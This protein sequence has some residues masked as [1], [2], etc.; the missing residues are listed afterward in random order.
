MMPKVSPSPQDDTKREQKIL[1]K[2]VNDGGED[3]SAQE[4]GRIQ[5]QL[6]ITPRLDRYLAQASHPVLDKFFS[7]NPYFVTQHQLHSYNKFINQGIRAIVRSMNADFK[8]IKPETVTIEGEERQ[9]L[10]TVQVMMGGDEEASGIYLDRPTV[11]DVSTGKSRLMFPNEA[12][13]RGF[14]YT[15]NVYCDITLVYETDGVQVGKNV[16]PRYRIGNI[17]VMLHSDMCALHGQPKATLA[18]M[19]E[20]IYDH[21]GYFVVDGKEKVIVS[22]E[23]LVYNRL[24]VSEATDKDK[25]PFVAY[26]A[27]VRAVSPDGDDLFPKTVRFMVY[28]NDY[29]QRWNAIDIQI[30][31]VQ[32]KVPLFVLFRALGLESDLRIFQ[33]VLGEDFDPSSAM[34]G[35]LRSCALASGD[36]GVYDQL[37]AASFLVERTNYKTAERMKQILADDLFP[38]AG[39]NF[40]NK[41]VYLAFLVNK[42]LRVSVGVDPVTDRDTYEHK[43]VHVT[44]NKLANLFRD[45]YARFRKVAKNRLDFEYYSGPWR[46]RAKESDRQSLVDATSDLV[47]LVNA[48]NERSIFD[49][50]IVD[51]GIRESFKGAWNKD[52]TANKGKED[53]FKEEGVVQ[54]LSRVSY[55][56]YLS[57][58]R[59]VVWAGDVAKMKS[60]H[61]LYATQYGIVCPVESPDGPNIGITKHMA[62][63]CH[64][65]LFARPDPLVHHLVR[66]GCV[67]QARL[68]SS[69]SVACSVRSK[70]I[71]DE[72][73]KV[74]ANDIL[75][76]STTPKDAAEMDRYL[77]AL[78]RN[79]LVNPMTSFRYEV[80]RKEF[81][82]LTDEG[83][84]TRPLFVADAE[85]PPEVP[86]QT[87]KPVKLRVSTLYPSLDALRSPTTSWRDL[88][89]GSLLT[90]AEKDEMLPEST[91]VALSVLHPGEEKRGVFSKHA[92]AS[93]EDVVDRTRSLD[94]TAGVLE[95]V[96]VEEANARLIAGSPLDFERRPCQRYS[97]CEIH[98]S[99]LLSVPAA[100]MPFM[101]RNGVN[102]DVLVM[103]QSKQSVGLPFTNFGNRMDTMAASLFYPQRPLV[104]TSFA[105]RLCDGN[106]VYGENVVVAIASFTGYNQEDAVIL[107]KGSVQ[108]GALNSTHIHTVSFEEDSSSRER[109][110]I[111]NPLL[112]PTVDFG[113][114][115]F[116]RGIRD[117]AEREEALRERVEERRR[118]F[119][120]IDAAGLPRVGTYAQEGDVLVGRIHILTETVSST[121]DIG[122]TRSE[123]REIRT[124]A[125]EV[126]ERSTVGLVDRVFMSGKRG[127]VRISQVRVPEFGDKFASRHSQKGVVGMVV[128]TR[129][130]PFG[131][132]TGTVPDVIINPH[133]IPSRMTVG[134]ILE[135]ALSKSCAL[136]GRRLKYDNFEKNDLVEEI[137]R[138]DYGFEKRGNELMYNA[139]TGEQI[140]SAV[141]VGPT[142]YMRL[143]HMV[144]D[145]INH[146]ATGPR[147]AVTR[148][149]NKG[150]GKHGGLRIGEMEQQAINSH[151]AAAF[152]KE[153]FMERC[154]KSSMDVDADEGIPVRVA[155]Q[156]DG[157]LIAHEDDN[158]DIRRV[159]V[160]HSFKVMQQ[161]LQAMSIDMRLLLDEEIHRPISPDVDIDID[162]DDDSSP[163]NYEEDKINKRNANRDYGDRPPP[164]ART[165][166]HDLVRDVLGNTHENEYAPLEQDAVCGLDAIEIMRNKRDS[167][168]DD[169]S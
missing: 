120:N 151:G 14:T 168:D 99:V 88:L 23:S 124:D 85:A 136:G 162:V 48:S 156:K 125:S 63:T 75:V 106:L 78:R 77:S 107:H 158:V 142:Y 41:T 3:I 83:R 135:A 118:R 122:F 25:P 80:F 74:I 95:L 44:G 20:C 11:K 91:G 70:D 79:G 31:G 159:E 22:R 2:T 29:T 163:S 155:N 54:E 1:V 53:E 137:L 147:T 98:P 24:F 110:V 131:A 160:P 154:D 116:L 164:D 169:E 126:V 30:P 38:N 102:R 129:D 28:A 58:V 43:R 65:T 165:R 161:E 92:A 42:L 94:R 139:R 62:V 33:A 130:M 47:N 56:G 143:K 113:D 148:Q 145:K 105:D 127:K 167:N 61:Y 16:L 39:R 35:I 71:E 76:G 68:S 19:G 152:L 59:R 8:M 153:A 69:S 12:R 55:L 26:H 138:H 100:C 18:E 117:S 21:G 89:L 67:R 9:V 93:K 66:I 10:R 57:H 114:E 52:R 50:S 5:T 140:P 64:V 27:W 115:R 119:A 7:H 73:V 49:A 32:G 123:T 166:L 133:G 149:P 13:L 34:V 141:F 121:D 60:P 87:N 104:T 150:R 51:T 157:T 86:G 108:R 144:A 37:E 134:H 111:G 15:T 36:A 103:A 82:I 97:H 81:V 84:C 46:K 128:P 132:L 17:P 40:E 4:R 6:Q 96:D 90:E 146:R 72:E 45:I 101:D 109:I 112:D